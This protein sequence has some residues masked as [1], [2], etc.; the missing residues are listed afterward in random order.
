MKNDPEKDLSPRPIHPSVMNKLNDFSWETILSMSKEYTA[1]IDDRRTELRKFEKQLNLMHLL[2]MERI[3][4]QHKDE[5][6]EPQVLVDL[7]RLIEHAQKIEDHYELDLND[8]NSYLYLVV[9]KVKKHK[10]AKIHHVNIKGPD[11]RRYRPLNEDGHK[12]H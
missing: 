10:L 3:R 11:S 1:R 4:E 9:Q 2:L 8:F 7:I 5:S 6:I 12:D